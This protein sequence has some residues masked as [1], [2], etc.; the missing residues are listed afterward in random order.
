MQ[1][2]KVSLIPYEGKIITGLGFGYLEVPSKTFSIS[3][4]NISDWRPG[5]ALNSCIISSATVQDK[6]CIAA[7]C[8]SINW[9]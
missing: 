1:C 6:A 5:S 2:H 8:Q 7:F 9:F 3:V 4:M